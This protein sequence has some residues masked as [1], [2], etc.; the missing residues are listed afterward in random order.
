MKKKFI[1]LFFLVVMMTAFN[2]SAAAVSADGN[3]PVDTADGFGGQLF[4]ADSNGLLMKRHEEEHKRSLQKVRLDERRYD[5]FF[6][7]IPHLLLGGLC[8][9]IFYK[10]FFETLRLWVFKPAVNTDI[11]SNQSRFSNDFRPDW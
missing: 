5:A 1:L 3:K 11:T 4:L 8:A 10:H 2:R 7:A 6:K 9:Y